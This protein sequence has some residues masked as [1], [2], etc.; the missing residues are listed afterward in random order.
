MCYVKC[1]QF[2]FDRIGV[3]FMEMYTKIQ[4][5]KKLGKE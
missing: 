3:E 5:Q 1:N 4:N 2:D